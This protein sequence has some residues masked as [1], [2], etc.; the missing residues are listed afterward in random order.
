MD[1]ND[2]EMAE[3]HKIEGEKPA[4]NV[5]LRRVDW[6]FLLSNPKPAKSIIFG[7]AGLKEPLTIISE[8]VI[9]A[10]TDLM[11]SNFELAV[12][13]EPNTEII[14]EI[15]SALKPGGDCYI[16]WLLP[17]FAR[18]RSLET[19]LA[20]AGF[21]NIESYIPIPNQI[22][23][24]AKIWV[25]LNAPEAIDYSLKLYFKGNGKKTFIKRMRD[26]IWSLGPKPIAVF[27][28]L[29]S[30]KPNNL[31]IS[32]V[33][34]KPALHPKNHQETKKLML[35]EGEDIDNK[36]ILF[37]FIKGEKNPS[38]VIKTTRVAKYAY[39]LENETRTLKRLENQYPGLDGI[40][41]VLF[42]DCSSGLFT[43]G[44]TFIDGIQ[45]S[46]II[47][48]ENYR[49]LAFKTTLWLI[50]L[51][52]ETKMPNQSGTRLAHTML[53]ELIT[54]LNIS[55]E[56]AEETEPIIN[57]LRFRYSVC[58][59][60]DLA[61]QNVL[62][63]VKGNLGVIDWED[64]S[65]IWVPALDLIFFLTLQ[66]FYLENAWETGKYLEAYR[67]LLNPSTFAGG[68]FNECL[69]LY[70]SQFEIDFEDRKALR[71]LAIMTW[72]H[73]HMPDFINN[74][75]HLTNNMFFHLWEEELT[76]SRIHLPSAK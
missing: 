15:F 13:S 75:S 66:N 32:T 19:K 55:E 62:M 4:D 39:E 72:L 18:I 8:C 47:T 3:K 52:M 20:A 29:L 49:D 41:K 69:N 28:W 46:K 70:S 48:K 6:R 56:I 36:P 25:P 23:L 68:V 44:E 30:S 24:P 60:R 7:G 33:A 35:T 14:Q 43:V 9:D 67:N 50:K 17:P 58:G 12:A 10:S 11:D 26:I 5:L 38:S 74:P 16:E 65:L 73:A 71:I 57:S 1:K 59:H 27:P 22:Q 34:Q 63:D 51:G 53:S 31:L 40:P 21:C 64:S 2:R 54:H 37:I 76:Y 42:T 61:P 45:V